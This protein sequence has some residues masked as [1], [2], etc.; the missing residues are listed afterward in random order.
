LSR[1]SLLDTKVSSDPSIWLPAIISEAEKLATYCKV[2]ASKVGASWSKESTETGGGGQCHQEKD[3]VINYCRKLRKAVVA[4]R[5]NMKLL[6]EKMVL[7]FEQNYGNTSDIEV[8]QPETFILKQDSTPK[9][10][11]R[12][13]VKIK[14]FREANSK[15]DYYA[16]VR[17]SSPLPSVVSYSKTYSSNK[18]SMSSQTTIPHCPS[19][20]PTEEQSN[21]SNLSTQAEALP[22]AVEQTRLPTVDDSLV[23][24]ESVEFFDTFSELIESKPTE[25]NALQERQTSSV[26][27]D[28]KLCLEPFPDKTES[29]SHSPDMFTATH[30]DDDDS[31]LEDSS[32]TVPLDHIQPKG[33]VSDVKHEAKIP[34]TPSPSAGSPRESPRV[35]TSSLEAT[36]K[37]PLK[38]RLSR[39]KPSSKESA[40]TNSLPESSDDV[41]VDSTLR[42]STPVTSQSSKSYE[43]VVS[44]ELDLNEKARRALLRDSSDSDDSLAELKLSPRV[45]KT[46]KRCRLP[47]ELEDDPK[48]KAE[49]AVVVN[50]ITNLVRILKLTLNLFAQVL[51]NELNNLQNNFFVNR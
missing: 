32:K 4:T 41:V 26:E 23:N 15:Q 40:K 25:T 27:S 18:S 38:S 20:L 12:L 6:E 28:H 36:R 8:E 17:E 50:R 19:P 39:S 29:Y 3:K 51:T 46:K 37:K 11:K 21:D 34:T 45:K 22:I 14:N 1:K 7:K 33:E 13:I 10:G 35:D 31:D 44:S 49:C 47:L 43:S 16:E 5:L 24:D 2:L 30:T 42:T 9:A 48:L